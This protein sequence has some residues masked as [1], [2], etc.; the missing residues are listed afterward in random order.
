M[1]EFALP[2]QSSAATPLGSEKPGGRFRRGAVDRPPPA[3]LISSTFPFSV[4]GY[5]ELL[6]LRA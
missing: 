3:P 4:A 2:A 6:R 1:I 5:S